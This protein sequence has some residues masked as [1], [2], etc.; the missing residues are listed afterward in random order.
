MLKQTD[1]TVMITS[2]NII[3]N[4]VVVDKVSLIVKWWLL[5]KN[6]CF[7]CHTTK[8]DGKSCVYFVGLYYY[9]GVKAFVQ[10]W[11]IQKICILLMYSLINLCY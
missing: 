11:W 3:N 1:K 4:T 5:K 8:I 9:S 10:I 2:N 7:L 6:E